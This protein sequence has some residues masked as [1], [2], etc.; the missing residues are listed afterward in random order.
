MRLSHIH[1]VWNDFLGVKARY[2]CVSIKANLA[3]CNLH[4]KTKEDCEDTDSCRDDDDYN[5]KLPQRLIEALRRLK[6]LVAC[7]PVAMS[8]SWIGIA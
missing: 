1:S 7:R 6:L 5:P 4:T 2:L 3:Q 8:A